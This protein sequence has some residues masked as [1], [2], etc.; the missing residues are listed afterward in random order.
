MIKT[1]EFKV[2]KRFQEDG[3]INTGM[4]PKLDNGFDAIRNGVSE[5]VITNSTAL[6]ELNDLGT[7]LVL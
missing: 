5:V 7:R 6:K 1:L 3:T 4:I 2:F